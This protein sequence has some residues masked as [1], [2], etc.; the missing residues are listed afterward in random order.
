M[1]SALGLS[2]IS[3]NPVAKVFDGCS[4]AAQKLPM[5]FLKSTSNLFLLKEALAKQ[6]MA[7][8][9]LTKSCLQL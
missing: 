9:L 8:K 1:R 2:Q 7:S 4:K 6:Y 3:L 5:A